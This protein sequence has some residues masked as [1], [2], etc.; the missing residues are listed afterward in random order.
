MKKKEIYNSWMFSRD[1]EIYDFTSSIISCV[2]D[3]KYYDE[4]NNDV[5]GI[6]VFGPYNEKII[7][8]SKIIINKNDH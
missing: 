4:N 3:G 1:C 5:C 8:N 7:N 2:C 6:K